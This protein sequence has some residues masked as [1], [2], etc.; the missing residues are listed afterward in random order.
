M[1]KQQH[2]I[3][4]QKSKKNALAVIERKRQAVERRRYFR[5]GDR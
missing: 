4:Y 3:G 1:S 2:D 5:R